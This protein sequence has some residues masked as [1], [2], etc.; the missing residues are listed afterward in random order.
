[1]ETNE[2]IE[3]SLEVEGDG[4]Y[5]AEEMQKF[6]GVT[7]GDEVES[8]T[9]HEVAQEASPDTDGT[10]AEA[11]NETADEAPDETSSETADQAADERGK[12][13]DRRRSG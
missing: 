6:H 13:R 3:I 7:F 1:M 8:D 12:L 9:T 10:D 2:R 5:S 4:E 11:D